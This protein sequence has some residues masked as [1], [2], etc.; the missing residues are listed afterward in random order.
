VEP[1]SL[2]GA[3]IEG[4]RAAKI[5]V[6]EY[7][8][9]QCP[10]CGRFANE[11]FPEFE[12]QYVQSGKVLFAFRQFPLESIHPYA[13]KAAEATECAADQGKFWALHTL[14]F[15]DQ[16]HLDDTALFEHAA[17]TGL[18]VQR[19]G[20]CLRGDVASR[21]RAD[22]QTG[23]RMLVSGTPTFFIGTIQADGRVKVVRRLSGAVPFEQFKAAVDKVMTSPAVVTRKSN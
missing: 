14:T 4:D 1:A 22:E 16:S 9:F 12:K 2:G 15:A 5:A 11:T 20:K 19:F 18:D 6:I 13:L 10:Y 7:S 23:Q 21:V 3:Q 17:K 8:D